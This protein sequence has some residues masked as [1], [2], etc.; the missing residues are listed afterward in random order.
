MHHVYSPWIARCSTRLRAL[1]S[2]DLI[3]LPFAQEMIFKQGQD[4]LRSAGADKL[5]VHAL[6]YVCGTPGGSKYQAGTFSEHGVCGEA[7][8][9]KDREYRICLRRAIQTPAK[10]C[11]QVRPGS[12]K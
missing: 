9:S 7:I 2:A 3:A 1:N 10:D 8:S 5:K 4:S 12:R 11:N 6:A